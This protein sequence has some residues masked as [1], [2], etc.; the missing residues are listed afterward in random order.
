M[1]DVFVKSP[2]KTAAP[3]GESPRQSRGRDRA[4]SDG[5]AALSTLGIGLAS[6]DSDLRYLDINDWLASAQGLSP[7]E[8]RGRVL[9]EII[10]H[11][12]VQLEPV[13][14][15]VLA[16]GLAAL[17]VPIRESGRGVQTARHWL[18]R[19]YPLRDDEGVS[20]V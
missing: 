8:H 20:G 14:R 5:A 2:L 9:N 11:L 15:R 6:L 10:P 4:L 3:P 19:C 1:A 12:A 13:I 7:A 17:D 16:T 18:V